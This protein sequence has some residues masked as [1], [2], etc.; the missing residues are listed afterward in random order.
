MGKLLDFASLRQGV[1]F[2]LVLSLGACADTPLVPAPPQPVVMRSPQPTI[3]PVPLPVVPLSDTST[4]APAAP[5]TRIYPGDDG[6]AVPRPARI[7]GGTRPEGDV[8][9]DF[10]DVELKDVVRAVLGD[11]L[12][13]SFAVDPSVT[14]RVTLQVTRPIARDDVLPALEAALKVNGVAIVLADGL[15]SVV[16]LGDAQRRVEGLSDT[17]GPGYGVEIAPLRYIAAPEMQKLLEPFAPAGGILRVDAARNIL[18]LVGTAQD[19]RAMRDTIATFDVDWLAGMSYALIRPKNIDAVS[20]ATELKGIFADEGS[21]ITGLVRFIPIARLNTLLVASPRRAYLDQ[22]TTWV[23]RLDLPVIDPGRQIHY[24][25]LQNAKAADIAATLGGLF[26]VA[27]NGPASA[28]GSV[29]PMPAPYDSTDAAMSGMAPSAPSI[30]SLGTRDTAGGSQI[31]TD[32]A[33]NALII[34]ADASEYQAIEAI[35]RE[36][37]VE[38]DQV[39]I[40]V[41]IAEVSLTGELRYGVEWFF[42]N[43]HVAGSLSRTAAVA[44][45]FPGFNFSYLIDSTKVVISALEVV[46]DVNVVSSP[47]LLTLDNKPATLQVGDEVPVVTQTAVSVIDPDAPVVNAVE[48]RDTGILMTVTP[49]FRRAGLSYS[50]LPRR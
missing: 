46:T 24:Y 25:R 33:N 1:T 23:D 14:G 48:M 29:L 7:S 28:A 12:H 5:R 16:P 35:I 42:S 31:V 11:I 45:Q 41:T 47:K 19:R 2:V 44:P 8:V 21:P 26:K 6:A 40:Q 39:L 32:D 10:V 50:I 3:S 13:V 22:V 4:A 30:A 17:S 27:G 9:L 49:G 43:D 36:M 15:Y 38:P 37:D 34:R 20:L 18:F